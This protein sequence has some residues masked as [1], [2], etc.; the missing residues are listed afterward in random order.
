MQAYLIQHSKLH[1]VHMWQFEAWVNRGPLGPFFLEDF[2]NQINNIL[3]VS[4]D[5]DEKVIIY[6]IHFS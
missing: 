4:L 1:M 6:A 5:I 2:R 3:F